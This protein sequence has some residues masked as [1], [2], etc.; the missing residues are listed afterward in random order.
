MKSIRPD[1]D[2]PRESDAPTDDAGIA[3]PAVPADGALTDS[4]G[5]ARITAVA[6]MRGP[7]HALSDGALLASPL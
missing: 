1:G 4:E 6:G 2:T 5:D 7:P 3:D